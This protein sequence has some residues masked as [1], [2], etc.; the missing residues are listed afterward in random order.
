MIPTGS[1]SELTSMDLSSTG[2]GFAAGTEKNVLYINS[3]AVTIVNC[4]TTAVVKDVISSGI[5]DQVQKLWGE[6]FKF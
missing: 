6:E 4:G 3:S 2:E 5:G 1:V